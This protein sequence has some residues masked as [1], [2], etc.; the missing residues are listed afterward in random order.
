MR[1][2]EKLFSRMWGPRRWGGGSEPLCWRTSTCKYLEVKVTGDSE[3]TDLILMILV[4]E[5]KYLGLDNHENEVWDFI[6]TV[7]RNIIDRLLSIWHDWRSAWRLWNSQLSVG[8]YWTIGKRERSY[9]FRQEIIRPW[10][11]M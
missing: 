3:E 6:F 11:R 5:W 4:R 9:E 8:I 7:L 1:V 10:S 2:V